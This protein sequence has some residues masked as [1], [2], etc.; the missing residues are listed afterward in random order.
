M[1]E[2]KVQK[3]EVLPIVGSEKNMH[4]NDIYNTQGLHERAENDEIS[5]WEEGFMTGY[6]E[7]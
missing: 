6:L 2:I 3:A 7:T 1:F 4:S 5:A